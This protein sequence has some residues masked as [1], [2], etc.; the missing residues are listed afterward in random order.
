MTWWTFD[1]SKMSDVSVAAMMVLNRR[2]AEYYSVAEVIAVAQHKANTSTSWRAAKGGGTS[3]DIR[4]TE[5]KHE[6]GHALDGS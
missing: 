6:T 2:Y 5:G 4:G 1:S 3:E